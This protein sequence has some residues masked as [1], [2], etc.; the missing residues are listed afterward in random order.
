[1]PTH[2]SDIFVSPKKVSLFL[3]MSL[4][5]EV[6]DFRKSADCYPGDGEIWGFKFLEWNIK[7]IKEIYF[8]NIFLIKF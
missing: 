4:F 1:M 3:E 5:W 7:E 6:E 8:I 2:N